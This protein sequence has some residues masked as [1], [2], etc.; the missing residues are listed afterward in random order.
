MWSKFW[1]FIGRLIVE[2]ADMPPPAPQISEP[3]APLGTER[4][5]NRTKPRGW[6]FGSRS[7]REL[8]TMD[9]QLVK[10]FRRALEISTVDF[11]VLDGGRTLAEQ[12]Q[13]VKSGASQTLNSKHI[14]GNA[15]DVG[16][17][18]DGELSWD[19]GHYLVIAT[20]F[21]IAADEMG[22]A[23][24]WGGAWNTPDIRKFARTPK[25]GRAMQDIYVQARRSQGLKPF[26]DSGHFELAS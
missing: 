5:V 18:I 16:A 17:F 2:T 15:G 3:S 8:A 24:R 19:G 12:K 1:A 20:A 22:V 23:I 21:A 10:V 11:G 6:R 4:P 7:E 9:P 26:I 25:A 14:G 13:H